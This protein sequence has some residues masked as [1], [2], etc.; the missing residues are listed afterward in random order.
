MI[1]VEGSAT[2]FQRILDLPPG[3]YQVKI[4]FL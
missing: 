4:G 2:V 1:K 3:Y